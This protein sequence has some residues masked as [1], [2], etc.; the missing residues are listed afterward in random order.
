MLLVC[1]FALF[2]LSRTRHWLGRTAMLAPAALGLVA[3]L[4]SVISARR[5]RRVEIHDGRRSAADHMGAGALAMPRCTDS[6]TTWARCLPK[7]WHSGL[8]LLAAYAVVIAAQ[9]QR[10][11]DVGCSLPRLRDARATA[12][13]EQHAWRCG[14][15]PCGRASTVLALPHCGL[16]IGV[17]VWVAYQAWPPRRGSWR[18]SAAA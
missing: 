1:A 12:L 15:Q 11:S 7:T 13:Q 18:S 4:A 16:L 3:A 8:P 10:R 9:P 6:S 2:W 14:A 5:E 17:A